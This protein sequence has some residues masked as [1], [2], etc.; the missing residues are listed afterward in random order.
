MPGRLDAVWS[1]MQIP[2][3]YNGKP[4][5]LAVPR[6]TSLVASPSLRS[7][8]FLSGGRRRMEGTWHRLCV[9]LLSLGE[10]YLLHHPVA[11]W[12]LGFRSVFLPEVS[13]VQT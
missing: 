5:N 11:L 13:L 6:T 1:F 9:L 8:R 4:D 7:L 3:R 2:T 12:S 10:Q